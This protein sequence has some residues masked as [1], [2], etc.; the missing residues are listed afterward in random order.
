M[1]K[2]AGRRFRILPLFQIKLLQNNNQ[3]K[4]IALLML[5]L[6]VTACHKNKDQITSITDYN[7]YLE[8]N[9][10]KTTSKFFELWNKKIKPDSLQLLSFG[11]VASEYNRYFKE[12]G[13][14]N[15]LK[16]AE[17]ALA[18]AVEIA[19][20]NK[21]GYRRA[22]AR[23][24]I[25]QHR[26]KE[27][28]QLAQEAQKLGGGLIATQQLLFDVHMELGN[29]K[30]AKAYL[31]SIQNPA[32]FGYLIRV[33]KWNDYK[34][35]LDTTIRFMEKAMAKAE[36][37]KNKTLQLWSYS[38]I[39]DY[40]GHA[41]RIEDSY[42]YYLK[43]LALENHNAYAKKGIAWIVFSHEKNPKE[44]LRILDIVTQ[45]YDAPDYYYLK[46]EIADFMRDK[47][48][49]AKNL[50]RYYES[51]NS[52]AYG[53]MYN[54][55][56]VGFHL[57]NSKDYSKALDL[58]LKEIENRP[59]PESYDLLVTTYLKMN[60]PKKALDLVEEHIMGKTFEPSILYHVAEVYKANQDLDKVEELKAELLGAIY[61]LGPAAQDEIENL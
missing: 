45:N 17:I 59:T 55:Y 57:E 37:S 14:I 12:T 54:A 7:K 42:K 47:S 34:G 23:N 9:H 18:K 6:L 51:V 2:R 29:Y 46:A 56:N 61:E 19:S 3:M 43:T 41:G 31:D 16:K 26:F 24:Y 48:E 13:D 49:K 11:N 15:F 33:A 32:D 39:A 4:R 52:L 36:S 1:N 25:S 28:L 5:V 53:D 58:A 27:A 21:E 38:N 10:T 20:I 30:T 8:I 22:L 44:A 60:K 35:D 50:D 40:Y